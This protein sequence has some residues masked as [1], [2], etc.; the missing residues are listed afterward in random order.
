MQQRV[1]ITGLGAVTPLGIGVDTFCEVPDFDAQRLLDRKTVG[2]TDRFSQFALVATDEAIAHAALNVEA[3]NRNR[4]GVIWGSGNGGIA[5]LENQI[6]EYAAGDG[7]PRFSPFLVP[8][9]IVDIT[10]G[11]ISIKYGFGGPSFAPVSACATSTTALC[12]AAL[13]VKAGLCD[14]VIA[15]GSEAALTASAVGG[16]SSAKALSQRNDDPQRA[17]RPFDVNRDG[18]VIGE[19][20]GAIVLE[21]YEHAVKRGATILAEVFGFAQTSDAYHMTATHPEG[22]GAARGMLQAIDY[23]GLQPGDINHINAHATSTPKGDISE[24]LAMNTVFGT[25]PVAISA[26]KSMTGHLLGA[27]GAVEAIATIKATM[28]DIVP[29][30]INLEERDP[31]I[32]P[33]LHIVANAAKELLVTYAMSN[34]FGFGGHN[35]IIIVGKPQ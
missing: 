32:P 15:G 5:T 35:A 8:K 21:S 17:S 7:T 23:A 34:T 13:Y 14:V 10:S 6:L 20:A 29:P 22:A 25:H 9:M 24:S 11:L 26:T 16:F 33:H 2:V 12:E 30:T 28:H 18:F 3:I 31:E 19:G 27:A 1:V 4:V